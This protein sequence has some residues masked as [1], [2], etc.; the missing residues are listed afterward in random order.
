M[1]DHTNLFKLLAA[2]SD[3]SKKTVEQRYSEISNFVA[4]CVGQLEW[5][6]TTPD[7]GLSKAKQDHNA[8]YLKDIVKLHSPPITS[9]DPGLDK[10]PLALGHALS[11]SVGQEGSIEQTE[12]LNQ[13]LGLSNLKLAENRTLLSSSLSPPLHCN[14]LDSS[15]TAH[16]SKYS[17]HQG[18]VS[19]RN[20]TTKHAADSS[21][22]SNIISQKSHNETLYYSTSGRPI[23]FVRRQPKAGSAERKALF[24]T[25]L[26]I[27]HIAPQIESTR[28]LLPSS[29]ESCTAIGNVTSPPVR[30]LAPSKHVTDR[31]TLLHDHKLSLSDPRNRQQVHARTQN[32]SSQEHATDGDLI[33]EGVSDEF[34][35][36]KIKAEEMQ[37]PREACN[38]S[39]VTL[40]D[41]SLPD[42]NTG[43]PERESAREPVLFKRKRG[44]KRRGSFADNKYGL[45]SKRVF[46]SSESTGCSSNAKNPDAVSLKE[47]SGN[48]TAFGPESQMIGT[49]VDDFWDSVNVDR[50]EVDNDEVNGLHARKP[51]RSAGPCITKKPSSPNE[52]SSLPNRR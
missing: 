28:S 37:E 8:R 23:E 49:E 27:L 52:Y 29:S 9:L 47:G 46:S 2:R 16:P 14:S 19:S 6:S 36:N 30:K 10:V 34:I 50:R 15:S 33:N 31:L 43:D 12:Q 5:V 42:S 17:K 24:D 39:K 45:S 44:T 25:A 18:P 26:S 1:P 38:S 35:R 13:V 7:P 21:M 20:L 41:A 3:V 11:R 51:T 4:H 40:D 48:K 22:N 32:G